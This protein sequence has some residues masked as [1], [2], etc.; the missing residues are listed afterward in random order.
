MFA[1]LGRRLPGTICRIGGGQLLRTQFH[2]P[3]IALVLSTVR[4]GTGSSGSHFSSQGSL[5]RS[6]KGTICGGR[7]HHIF[8]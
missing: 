4:A 3:A 1:S 8:F 7:G 6:G 2:R 5:S